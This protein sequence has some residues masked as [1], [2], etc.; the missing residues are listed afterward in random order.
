MELLLWFALFIVFLA[1]LI[2]SADRFV[3]F[4][5]RI[6][7]MLGI[8]Q[9]VIG[10][11]IIALGTSAPE[12][13]TSLFA[14][15]LGTSDFVAG[16][17]VGSNVANLLFIVGMSAL[18]VK[19]IY[20][21]WNLVK[22]DIPILAATTLL[23]I[24]TLYDGTVY[25]YEGLI[26]LAGYA[27]YIW[28]FATLHRE[29]PGIRV[30]SESMLPNIIFLLLAIAGVYAGARVSMLSL[31]KISELIG[32][33]TSFL[34]ATVFAFA[35]SLPELIVSLAAIRRKNVELALGNILGSNVFNSTIILGLPALLTPVL[36]PESIIV[37]GIPFLIGAVALYAI[38]LLDR[39]ISKF[40]G[41]Y[42][43][44]L[45]ALFIV[46]ILLFK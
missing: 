35:T 31:I 34:A 2:F 1:V 23:L 13:V 19:T 38:S 40:E 14:V 44:L 26:L 36:V 8:P 3:K 15:M 39:K 21:K 29:E 16:T 37:V 24:F 32:R 10:I 45:Y 6:G 30:H 5:S 18:M 11:T 28:Y 46:S 20:S 4:G 27:A 22:I 42:F 43:L 12:L 17:V 33:H 41:L 9:F 25:W 7:V